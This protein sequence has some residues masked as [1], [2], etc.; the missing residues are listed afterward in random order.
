M[1]FQPIYYEFFTTSDCPFGIFEFSLM[2]LI[3]QCQNFSSLVL[4]PFL[5]A[6]F[7]VIGTCYIDQ[8][9]S[10]LLIV[11]IVFIFYKTLPVHCIYVFF[12]VLK[13]LRHLINDIK[14]DT[15]LTINNPWTKNWPS[16]RQGK[17]LK[18]YILCMLY[19]LSL[20]GT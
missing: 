5:S 9:V 20:D 10:L 2:H 11:D 6:T 12:Y 8:E 14:L 7:F 3:L 17:D 15:V 1:L 16:C 19:T 18:I 13:E 4:W